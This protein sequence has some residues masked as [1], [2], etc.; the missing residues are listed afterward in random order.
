MHLLVEVANTSLSF[1]RNT[2]ARLYAVAGIA[3]YWIINLP[4][5]CFEVL[6]DPG[7]DGY[8]TKLVSTPGD[9]IRPLAFP[10]LAFPVSLIFPE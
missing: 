7:P 1:D 5:R 8:A 4:G 10:D 9:V 3:D 6:R 2:K